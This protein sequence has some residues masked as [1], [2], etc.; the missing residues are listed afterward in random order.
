M[1]TPEL[2]VLAEKVENLEHAVLKSEQSVLSQLRTALDSHQQ[3]H[4]AHEKAHGDEHS[5]TQRAVERA[6]DM[7]KQIAKDHETAHA[8]EHTMAKEQMDKADDAYEQRL[9]S[10]SRETTENFK[11]VTDRIET[12][13]RAN[14]SYQGRDRGVSLVW[15]VLIAAV[16]IGIAIVTFVTQ[17]R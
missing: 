3:L 17:W 5:Q 7:T 1:E 16:G 10:M 6:E 14:A 8:R 13:E 9:G 2:K 15:G 11:R 12:L 4:S